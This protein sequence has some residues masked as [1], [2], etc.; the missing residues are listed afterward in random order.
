MV[1]RNEDLI[2]VF[3]DQKNRIV[4]TQNPDLLSSIAF[5]FIA[6]LPSRNFNLNFQKYENL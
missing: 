6:T 1:K 2:E 3:K 4:D 5:M